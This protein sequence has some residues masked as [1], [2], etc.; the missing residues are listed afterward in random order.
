M[1]QIF[2]PASGQI[3]NAKDCMAFVQ[4]AFTEMGSEEPC[5]TCYE[6][7]AF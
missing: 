5:T 4:Q 2:Q 1:A 6:Y 7:P 3:I